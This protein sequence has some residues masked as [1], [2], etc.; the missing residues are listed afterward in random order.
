MT[1]ICS[2]KV[3]RVDILKI[4]FLTELEKSQ[5]ILLAGAG[6]GYDIFCGLPLYF[7]LRNAGKN[8]HL[9]NLS[10]SDIYRSD[11]KLMRPA[12]VEVSATIEH[13]TYYFP[14]KY[15]AQWF[16]QRG[17]EIPI[18]CFDRTGVQ[19]L[20]AAY[21]LL[22]GH[23]QLDTVILVD[24]GTD[25]LMRGD[26][27]VLGTPHEDVA[28]IAAVDLL[29]VANKYLVCLGFGI[30]NIS[31]GQFLEGVA[32]L[33]RTDGYLGSWSLTQQMPDVQ[34]Y[35]EATEFV[36]EAMPDHPSIIS[37]SILSALEGRFGDYHATYRTAGSKLFI[38]PLMSFYWCFRLKQVAERILYLKELR[39][40]NSMRDIHNVINNF[41]SNLPGDGRPWTDLPM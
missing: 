32:E 18:Y 20:L 34:L 4:P 35:R 33:I 15:L 40:T 22:V 3:V 31:H 26:E 17:E 41:L 12:L 23:L 1:V 5:N 38:N 6:G 19:P 28:S 30:D 16:K 29:D 8:V 9:A 39:E 25:S 37:A 2:I 24:G 7:A 36:F 11:A 14:E 21:Q 10:F 27:T 13:S